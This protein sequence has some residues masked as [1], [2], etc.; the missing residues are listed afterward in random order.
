M[1]IIYDYTDRDDPKYFTPQFPVLYHSRTP[2]NICIGQMKISK[3][4]MINKQII[5]T[6]AKQTLFMTIKIFTL[7]SNL[8]YDIYM[9]KIL[10]F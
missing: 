10:K 7:L 5:F 1:I 8:L 4:T 9:Y 3:F 2:N 6:S